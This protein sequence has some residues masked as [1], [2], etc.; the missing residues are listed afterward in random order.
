MWSRTSTCV[1]LGGALMGLVCLAGTHAHTRGM[2]V[3]QAVSGAAMTHYLG[4]G[5]TTDDRFVVAAR[6][7]QEATVQFDVGEN[8]DLS[9][10]SRTSGVTA[11]EANDFTAHATV[12][13][14]S[15][16]T[17]YFIAP[18]INGVR[19]GS[20]PWPMT[21]TFPTEGVD[22][23]LKI[24]VS[25]CQKRAT[26]AVTGCWIPAAAEN[27]LLHLQLGDFV[28]GDFNTLGTLRP[29]YQAEYTGLQQ[30][31]ITNLITRAQT[32]D[33]HD[34]GAN[35]GHGESTGVNLTRQVWREYVPS[36]PLWDPAH[37]IGYSFRIANCEFFVPDTREQRAAS[38]PRYPDGVG[39]EVLAQSGTTETVVKFPSSPSGPSG[40]G[41]GYYIR[42]HN[43]AG[44]PVYNRRIVNWVGLT[45][46]EA[47]LDRPVPGLTAGWSFSC[48]FSSM[49]DKD[50]LPNGQVERLCSGI[51]TSTARWKFFATSVIWNRHFVSTSGLDD[52]WARWDPEWYEREYIRERLAPIPNIIVLSGDRHFGGIT[53]GLAAPEGPDWPEMT[54]SAFHRVPLTPVAI[55]SHGA[56]STT[57]S[58][59]LIEIDGVA[60]TCTLTVKTDTGA[61][62][63]SG[64]QPISLV[65]ED[66][67]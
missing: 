7:D 31:Y 17:T 35:N 6:A 52:C 24:V 53:D 41:L 4:T 36:Y 48:K 8:S 61:V 45:T 50:V 38:R 47:T 12:T 43:G 49:L 29:A 66:A 62:A 60:H 39:N 22:A 20:A 65:L 55:W 51:E 30:Q 2:G 26:D 64:G 14:R 25:S 15:P 10:A 11:L 42:L 23:S 37:H 59:G 44:G 3:P 63:M 58:Y 1:Y 27:A 46:R 57:P 67:A 13:G 54:A 40:G 33:D 34:S 21:R 9:D 18:V 19:Q 16:N 56:Y 28:Y 5:G 32:K